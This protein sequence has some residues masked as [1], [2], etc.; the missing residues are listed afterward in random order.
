V[1]RVKTI[2]VP[3]GASGED[4]ARKNPKSPQ[5]IGGLRGSAEAAAK[6]R[7]KRK[8]REGRK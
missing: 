7:E 4:V 8:E 3:I 1:S 2:R 6:R 5:R